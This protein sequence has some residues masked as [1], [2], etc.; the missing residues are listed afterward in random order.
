LLLFQR[1]GILLPVP[2]S[3]GSQPAVLPAPGG[4]SAPSLHRYLHL[5]EQT[6]HRERER[7]THTHK[8]IHII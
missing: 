3:G 4:Y 1:T 8:D 5:N 6:P 2:T 7:E